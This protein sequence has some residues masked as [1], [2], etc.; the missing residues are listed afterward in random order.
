M[1]LIGSFTRTNTGYSGALHTLILDRAVVLVAL[2][3][4]TLETAPDYRVHLDD[5]DGPE[6]GAGW[7]CASDKAGDYVSLSIDD[8]TLTQPIHAYLFQ[9][10]DDQTAWDLH[11]K[12]PA[13]STTQD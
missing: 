6:I 4:G 3:R 1:T 12:R 8:P 5:A 2:E 13:K 7:K 11:W 9:S 10:G